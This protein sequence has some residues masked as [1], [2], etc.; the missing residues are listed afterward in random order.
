MVNERPS[1][2]ANARDGGRVKG[3]ARESSNGDAL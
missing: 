1:R 3:P 2:G